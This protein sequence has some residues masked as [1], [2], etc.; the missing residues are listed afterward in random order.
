MDFTGNYRALVVNNVDPDGLNRIQMQIPQLG[1]SHSGW[2]LPVP[3]DGVVPEVG[4]QVIA[5][6]EGGD[7]S[8]PLYF[9]GSGIDEA[10]VSDLVNNAVATSTSAVLRIDSSRG[11]TFKSST[12]STVLSVT[13][14]VG[15]Q[16]VS[17]ATTMRQIFGA[18]AYLEWWWRRIDDSDFGVI[19]SSDSRIG[20]DG[21]TLTVSPADVDEQT[22]FQC[23]LHT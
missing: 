13:I 14:F 16:Q 12:F 9:A 2:A 21:F 8:H 6:F 22:V 23:V 3:A 7:L 10:A 18:G 5:T 11:T 1:V 19:S 4:A 15:P 17:D 20:Q